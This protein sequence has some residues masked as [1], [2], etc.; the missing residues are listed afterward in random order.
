MAIPTTGSG[1]PTTERPHSP[2][3]TDP[4]PPVLVDQFDTP[5]LLQ[6]DLG[7]ASSPFNQLFILTGTAIV[8]FQFGTVVLF[9]QRFDLLLSKAYNGMLFNPNPGGTEVIASA[10][11]SSIHSGDTGTWAIDRAFP[12]I[13]SKGELIVHAD[14]AI[15]GE[16]NIIS[17]LAYQVFLQTSG[18]QIRD[19][20][21]PPVPITVAADPVSFVIKL[22]PLQ[23]NPGGAVRLG[24]TGPP[25]KTV[26]DLLMP[27]SIIVEPGAVSLDINGTLRP[28][29]FPFGDTNVEIDFLTTVSVFTVKLTLRQL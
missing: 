7:A 8:E 19:A 16:D 12:E 4:D 28:N 11:L 13:N 20:E 2:Q 18:M 10:S 27:D 9:P 25:D 26:F 3:P 21:L 5:Q 23:P 14:L 24:L 6:V 1:V 15:Q 22:F 17:R 29:H